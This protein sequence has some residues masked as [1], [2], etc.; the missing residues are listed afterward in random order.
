[1]SFFDHG[2]PEEFLLFVR[3]FIITIAAPGTL[4][5]DVKVQYICTI[6]HGEALHKFDMLYV[7]V[8]NM[9]TTLTVDY[10]IKGLA[11]YFYL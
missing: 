11:W 10:L 4:E 8:E 6:I 1:M 5:T 2:D 9:D 7:D 3:N